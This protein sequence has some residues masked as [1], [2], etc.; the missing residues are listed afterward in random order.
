MLEGESMNHWVKRTVAAG[1]GLALLGG[2]F[3]G[4]AQAE[5]KET[6]EK[7][8]T[9][10][11]CA[12]PDQ[13]DQY[14]HGYAVAGMSVSGISKDCLRSYELD[15]GLLDGDVDRAFTERADR[16]LLR[17]GSAMLDGLYAMALHE[18]GQL[19]VNSVSNDAY[20]NNQPMDCTADGTG[21][22]IT[23]KNWSYVWTRDMAYAVDL[24][25][26][27]VDPV[28]ARNSLQFKLS[29]RREGG[30][31][32]II[33]DTGTGGSYPNSSD[34]VSWA[35]GALEV[36]PWLDDAK[37]SAFA[38][39]SLEAIRNTIE[40]DRGVVY[41]PSTGL[42][43]G[44]MSHSDWRQQ[45]YPYWTAEDVTDITTSQSL[46]NNVT[47]WVAIDAAARL[48]ETAGRADDA[49][50]YRGWADD[51]ATSIR[52]EFWLKDR[53]QFSNLLANA[54]NQSASERYE[55]LATALVVLTGIADED[56]A[57]AAIANYPQNPFGPSIIWPQQQEDERSYH[58][59]GVW[60][61]VT[62]Y[63]MQAAAKV[64]N[65]QAAAAQIDSLIYSSA[66][67]ASNYENLNITTG[68]IDTALNSER[69]TW[70][71]AGMLGV[72]QDVLFGIDAVDE[73]LVV[74]PF[75]PAQVRRQFF[76]TQSQISLNRIDFRGHSV[77]VVL[78]LPADDAAEGAYTVTGLTVDGVAHAPGTL[79]SA[80]QLSNHS[81]VRVQL[82]AAKPTVEGPKV[83]S[84]YNKD[85][86]DWPEPYAGDQAMFGPKIPTITDVPKPDADR[87]TL[88]LSLDL[89]G[90]DV[91]S[92]DIIRDGIVVADNIKPSATWVDTDAAAQ[93]RISYCYSVRTT[94]ASGNTSHD[95]K[96][97]CYWGDAF[98]RVHKIE[99]KDFTVKGGG[100]PV[101]KD[102]VL[103]HYPGWG[104]G[105]DDSISVQ[106]TPEV[107]GTYLIQTDYALGYDIRS[108]VSSAIK[109]V[110]VTDGDTEVGGGIL[111]MPNT[112]KWDAERGSTFVPVNLQAGTAYTVKLKNDRSTANMSYFQAN[113]FY[114]HTKEA[115]EN[116]A[117]VFRIKAM[118][119]LA[120][121]DQ[122]TVAI[123]EASNK[124]AEV[125]Q[126]V[127]LKALIS[128]ESAI[129]ADDVRDAVSINWGDDSAIEPFAEPTAAGDDFVG[130]GSHRYAKPG[131]YTVTVTAHGAKGDSTVEHTV[132]VRDLVAL[133]IDPAAPD[134]KD[135]WFVSTTTAVLSL[136]SP[137]A[138]RA[139]GPT[140]QYRFDE[141]GSW[142]AYATAL[143]LEEGAHKLGYRSV[144]AAGREGLAKSAD[145][146]VD[147]VAP[148]VT[149]SAKLGE[150]DATV[151][152]SATDAT[153][154]LARIEYRLG[155]ADQWTP[156]T[157]EFKVPRAEQPRSV[158]YRAVDVA[159]NTGATQNLPI[160][161][162]PAGPT[163]T[164]EVAKV[165]VDEA[166]IAKP[167][168]VYTVDYFVNGSASPSGSVQVK[169][170]E[171]VKLEQGLA[172]GTTVT[173]T[174]RAPE[175]VATGTW[176][177][178][179][180][181]PGKVVIAEDATPTVTVTN[182]LTQNRGSF[183]IAKQVAGAEADDTEFT[184]T[185]TVGGKD[186]TVKV[187]PAE[188][189]TSEPLP[190]GSVVT[191]KETGT[192]EIDNLRFDGVSYAGKGVKVA[193]GEASF[194]V[195]SGTTVV[196][197]INTYADENS[198]KP[199]PSATP[200]SGDDGKP[201][202][203]LPSS[204]AMGAMGLVALAALGGA[205]ALLVTR[206]RR[207]A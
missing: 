182:T 169:A 68:D 86:D 67:F 140:L 137:S 78:D 98:N 104:S 23:G 143:K 83:V 14:Q 66:M 77:D 189:W 74:N 16:P 45:T 129:T 22:Y 2:A 84:T 106:F 40:H 35:I 166:G 101:Y 178:A 4:T 108:G 168:A 52:T 19:S 31:L 90:E 132:V 134:G 163:G 130:E 92:M 172:V 194:T 152:L 186:S 176:Q 28:R 188:A 155:D 125:G 49:A 47:H 55:S 138:G 201:E 185:Y 87:E 20:N 165:V 158:Q 11:L 88:E 26:A 18:E 100:E 102:G 42:Y 113:A 207:R 206:L 89:K 126:D 204:G 27:A 46:S 170:G 60:P 117:D 32:Q 181:E 82:G 197:A 118:L 71:V 6:L 8:G 24:G 30:D 193:D 205:G 29:E 133:T 61:F 73:G 10:D 136:G 7:S 91:E 39:Q 112:D 76:P 50:K 119:K 159:G 15:S 94:Y 64:G 1:I 81:V 43:L 97:V 56:Q 156:Y 51:L 183:S 157:D 44:E 110:S 203:G 72:F 123:D 114:N 198:P 147:T 131:T 122:M 58:N 3:S 145:L 95:A 174:E 202:P 9:V 36:L 142:Q 154:G 103:S 141:A 124:E 37:R 151:G 25:L 57:A 199:S 144:G 127:L 135:G 161:Q 5:P 116:I 160:E 62:A 167:D 120:A 80:D 70:S 149:G 179:V 191:V 85:G 33:Q 162:L 148:A 34:R 79:I 75:V 65:D 96:P 48:S 171:K 63:M 146:K 111:V 200:T 121:V 69:Q 93:D 187:T 99:A 195:G 109:R 21:C 13:A 150:T 180:I 177:E 17:T 53:G 175:V 184:F 196:T 59:K 128:S 54:F 12:L 139:E 105:D 164:F 153:S 41:N 38:E 115:P 107:A 190:Q 192:V 173:F